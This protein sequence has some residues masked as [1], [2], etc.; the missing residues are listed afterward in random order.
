VVAKQKYGKPTLAPKIS[1]TWKTGESG[2]SG[3][4]SIPGNTLD[5]NKAAS[6]NKATWIRACILREGKEAKAWAYK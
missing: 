1:N 3:R 5:A 2:D 6:T 4:S